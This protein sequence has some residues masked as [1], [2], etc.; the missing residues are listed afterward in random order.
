MIKNVLIDG[1]I[2]K[3]ANPDDAGY[4][5]IATS[6]PKIVGEPVGSQSYPGYWWKIQYI[7]YSV[8]IKIAPMQER[9]P[10]HTLVFPRG[11]V[12]KKNLILANSIGLVDAG[13]RDEMFVWF[14]YIF[15]PQ[16]FEF[17]DNGNI[18]GRVDQRSIYQKGDKIAQLV[19]SETI[20]PKFIEA[21]LSNDE[22]ER[23]LGKLGSTGT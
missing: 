18:A 9:G 21:D 17:T 13:Y 23:G 15:Q 7:E 12:A 1:P 14:K 10:F 19:F 4:D 8:G 22:T 2:P 11:S 6:D 16:D 5:V 3:Q 20:H